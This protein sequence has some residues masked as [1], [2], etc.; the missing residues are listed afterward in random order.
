MLSTLRLLLCLGFSPVAMS[1]AEPVDVELVLAVD[2]S[3][4]MDSGEFAL[5]RAGYVEAI[6]HPDFINAVRGGLN[7]RIA[8]TYFEWAGTVRK[9]SRVPWQIIDGPESAAS[10]AAT[11]ASRPF[12]GYQGT[13]ISTAILFGGSL[14]DDNSTDALRRVIDISGDGPNNLGMPVQSARDQAV[15]S[16]VII[17]G[18]P[19]LIRPSPSFRQLDR[20]YAACVV[21]G[22]GSFVLPI[23]MAS[24]FATAI[25]RKLVLEVSGRLP[26][27]KAVP[28]AEQ[29]VDCLK[30]ER[31]R[32][33]YS[34][35][36]FPELD[37]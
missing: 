19:I 13:S 25:R 5:Q 18:L 27:P 30:G 23:Y 37:R 7:G 8:I 34:D 36:Y 21:G 11:L 28:I 20:Y 16:G 24:E 22:A 10:F 1:A 14:F 2:V 35:P 6:R 12:G 33:T 31:D 32:Q 15:A 9:E 26:E 4:S 29:P 17:N 3:R